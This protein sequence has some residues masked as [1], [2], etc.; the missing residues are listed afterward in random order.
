MKTSYRAALA[1]PAVSLAAMLAMALPASAASDSG[2]NEA[3][4]APVALNDADGSGVAMT[5][6]KDDV[7]TVTFT[8]EGLLPD[9]PHAAHIH[10]GAEARHECPAASD[11]KDGSGTLNTTEGGPAYGDIVVSLT[12]TGDTS[13]RSGL[14]VDRFDTAKGGKISYQRGSIKVSHEVGEAIIA[15]KSVVVIHGVDHNGDGKYD[16]DTKSDLDP[17]LPTEATDPA[18]CGVLAVSQMSAMPSGGAQTGSGST[19]G[20]QDT[21]LLA[22]GGLAMAA[23]AVLVLRRRR[24]VVPAQQVGQHVDRTADDR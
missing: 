8:A 12:K 2:S 6:V 17:S 22:A 11:D 7:L 18:L 23:G 4:L 21:G 10:F 5:T 13:P 15:G 16:G 1:V 24:D 19:A 14:A 3:K 20:V 9:N